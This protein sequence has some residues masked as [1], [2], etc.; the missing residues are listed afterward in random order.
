MHHNTII[1]SNFI[2]HE[3]V[4]SVNAASSNVQ[5][6]LIEVTLKGSLQASNVTFGIFLLVFISLW[7]QSLPLDMVT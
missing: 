1:L 3:K 7:L 2:H 6:L 4:N 5:S